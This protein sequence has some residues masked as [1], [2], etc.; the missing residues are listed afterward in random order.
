MLKRVK[1]KIQENSKLVALSDQVLVSGSHF[2]VQLIFARALGIYNYGILTAMWLL[3]LFVSSFHQAY[4]ILP[5]LTLSSKHGK[6]YLFNLNKCQWLF[7]LLIVVLFI[8]F[9]L[10]NQKF[11]WFQLD[12]YIIP[13]VSLLI[14]FVSHDFYRK[15]FY[16]RQQIEK[17]LILDFVVY[18]VQIISILYFYF[19]RDLSIA[20][21]LG[22]VAI[23]YFL[24]LL[25]LN[26][27]KKDASDT[28]ETVQL[29]LIK[30]LDINWEF[31]K[32]LLAKSGLQ[33]FSG[34]FFLI[35]A[36]ALLGATALG[37]IR[38]AQN[39]VGIFNVLFL[40][41]ENVL[42]VKAIAKLKNEGG[43]ALSQFINDISRKGFFVIVACLGILLIFSRPIF[44]LIYGEV[45]NDT[46]Y[47][48]QGFCL[49]YLFV[50][51]STLKRIEITTL[52]ANQHIFIAY[53]L[54]SIF[55]LIIAYPLIKS[56]ALTGVIV[57]IVLSQIICLAYYQ[58]SLKNKIKLNE[59]YTFRTG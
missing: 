30:T 28:A 15:K 40:T 22:L 49:L 4:I 37:A 58:Y 23:S 47:V 21:C 1:E 35:A 5:M 27:F 19:M 14:G 8:P 16:A 59:N 7:N 29:N 13:L 17:A 20:T 51:L 11:A 42:P 43:L 36:S 34:N 12:A 9:C 57:G 38:M 44:T 54:S 6:S 45:T 48:F 46:L 31:S 52:E 50:Y 56:F 2:L 3:L 25:V 55:T 53:V 10:L 32:W 39:V 41:I 26:V 18:S 33:W 24:G